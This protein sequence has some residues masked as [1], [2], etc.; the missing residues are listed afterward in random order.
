[1]ARYIDWDDVANR[2][3][4]IKE[5]G[6]AIEVGDAYISYAESQIEGAL[7]SYY[8]V[9][10]SNNNQTVKDLAIELVY[11]R[12]GNLSIEETGELKKD[13]DKR[14]E[15]LKMGMS[16]MVDDSG[17]VIMQSVGEAI[18]SNTQNYNPVFGVGDIEDFQ[19]DSSQAYAEGLKRH[20]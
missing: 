17:N 7:A 11:I 3:P 10:F 9:P 1:M 13:Y 4:S 5:T 2:Y 6:G 18:W 15:D 16:Q 14:I 19:V 12:A 8:T 20:D